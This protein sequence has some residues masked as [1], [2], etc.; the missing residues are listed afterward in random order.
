LYTCWRGGKAR[1]A[2]FNFA[3]ADFGILFRSHFDERLESKVFAGVSF[4]SY[5]P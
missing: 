2:A 1:I 3:A 5:D 4:S